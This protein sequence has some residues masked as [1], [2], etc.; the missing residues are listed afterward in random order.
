MI[1]SKSNIGKWKEA[2][3]RRGEVAFINRDKNDELFVESL[4]KSQHRRIGV[5]INEKTR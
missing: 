4:M 2:L 3:R 1:E 5:G